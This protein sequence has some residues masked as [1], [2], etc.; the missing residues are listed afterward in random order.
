MISDGK[1]VTT[2]LMAL[3]YCSE[4]LLRDA[5]EHES[6]ISDIK[7]ELLT[8]E[9]RNAAKSELLLHASAESGGG[10]GVRGTERWGG[11][12]EVSSEDDKGT[13][14]TN[15]FMLKGVSGFVSCGDDVVP[16]IG[17]RQSV[18]LLNLLEDFRFP[19]LEK[20]ERFVTTWWIVR[21]I[22]RGT[23]DQ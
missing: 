11:G 2:R 1:S 5:E 10:G 7:K 12:G 9:L 17:W 8:I 18:A 15:S 22:A 3:L 21:G 20:H 19:G 16:C 23:Q 13:Q 6:F 4:V 14:V